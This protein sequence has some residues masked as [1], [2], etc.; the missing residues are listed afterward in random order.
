MP[1]AD[2]GSDHNPIVMTIGIKLRRVKRSKVRVKWKTDE[3]K[4]VV[5]RNAFQSK[6]NKQL[7]DKGVK[8]EEEIE[9]IWNKLKECVTDVASE[10]CGKEQNKKKQNWM[11]SDILD[12]MEERRKFKN[13]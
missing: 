2:C 4:D 1:G 13:T 8:E 11:N 5:K 3:L 10:I 12:M 7:K 6:L 9:Q